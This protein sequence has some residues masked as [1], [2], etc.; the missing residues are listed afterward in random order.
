VFYISLC[1]TEVNKSVEGQLLTDRDH[2]EHR[3]HDSDCMLPVVVGIVMVVHSHRHDPATQRLYSTLTLLCTATDR[4][5]DF[6]LTGTPLSMT[7]VLSVRPSVTLVIHAETVQD[8]E[9]KCI[10][11]HTTE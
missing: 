1:L 8:I 4:P 10:L 6:T 9:M 7:A 2:C 3:L 11:H 5:T